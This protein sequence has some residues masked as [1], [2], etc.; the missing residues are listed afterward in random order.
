LA[1]ARL[2]IELL[3]DEPQ[4]IYG[5]AA[6]AGGARK[7]GIGRIGMQY[8]DILYKVENAVA[9][10]TI[11]RPEKLNAMRG[12][13]IN[14][15]ESAIEAAEADKSVGVLVLT[16]A[17]ERAFS[18]GGDVDWELE[19]NLEGLDMR[20]NRLVLNC[21]KPVI[22]RVNGYAIASGNHIAYFCDF[23]IASEHSI[24]GQNGPRIGS[25]AAG[26]YVS[27]LAGII[28]HKRAREMWML[29]R[30]Y[31]AHQ[32]LDWGL[33]NAVVPKENLDEEVDRWCSELLALS[34]TCLKT[35]KRS[36]SR[37]V[38]QTPLVEILNEIAPDYFETGEQE[39]GARAF[40]EK[41]PP[42][43]SSWR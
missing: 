14:E 37:L 13:T 20:I 27:H 41:R 25:P 29:C 19:G 6:V 11:N 7:M 16:G 30:R 2:M 35:V 42:D 3:N 40:V 1:V 31:T 17:G 34:P 43:Y 9:T 8:Q 24:F 15:L 23:T 22:A 38:D 5:A 21:L 32:M 12:I 4:V 10:I 28:G 26:H 39:E 18:S 33:V 36:F